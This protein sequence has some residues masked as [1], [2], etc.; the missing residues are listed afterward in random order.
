MDRSIGTFFHSAIQNFFEAVFNFFVFLPYFFSVTTLLKTL[1]APWKNITVKKTIKRLSLSDIFNRFSYN[2]VSR[3]MGFFMRFSMITFY[4][5]LQTVYF[6]SLIV[7]VPLFIISIPLLYMWFLFED[8]QEEKKNRFIAGF[9]KNHLLKQENA[10]YVTSWAGKLYDQQ[11]KKSQWWK[12]SYLFSIPPLARDWAVGYT[13]QLDNYTTDLTSAEYQGHIKHIVGRVHEVS[14]IEQTLSRTE[15]GNVLI[16]G[17]EGVGKHAVLDAFTKR[18]YEGRINQL[19]AYKRILKVNMEKI[20]T[21]F[22]DQKQREEF[23]NEL[24]QEEV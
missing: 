4:V 18:V 13:P 2:L 16:V 14:L 7:I 9:V 17:E 1:F 6:V 19:L 5:I 12:L 15:E 21:E 23:F 10:V 22:T 8:S 3:G 20:L 11:Y 24:L